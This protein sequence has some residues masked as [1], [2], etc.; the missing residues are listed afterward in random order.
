MCKIESVGAAV[1][2]YIYVRF[3]VTTAALTMKITVLYEVM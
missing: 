1:S 2:L 3:E